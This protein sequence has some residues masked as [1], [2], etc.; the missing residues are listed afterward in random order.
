M[1]MELL[2]FA[3]FASYSIMIYSSVLWFS[4]FLA[5]RKRMW[6]N[7]SVKYT[8][9]VTFLVPAHNEENLIDRCLESIENLDYPKDKIKVIVIDDGST[10]S[11]GSVASRFGVKLIEQKHKGKAA[12]VNNALKHVKTELVACLDA[13]SVLDK[14]YLKKIVTHMKNKNVAAATPSLKVSHKNSLMRDIQYMEYLY[15][16]FLRRLFNF[17]D[18][19]YVIPGP[20]GIYKTEYLKKVGG[21]DEKNLTEDMEVAFR[22]IDN[23]YKIENSIDAYVHTEAPKTLKGLF[24]QRIRWYRGYLQNVFKYSHM[25]SNGKFGN[26]GIFLLPINFVWMIIIG[27]M[28]FALLFTNGAYLLSSFVDWSYIHYSIFTP[29]NLVDV[30][31]VGLYSYFTIVFAI[32]GFLNINLSLKYSGEKWRVKENLKMYF[33]YLFIYPLLIA[34]FWIVSIFQEIFKVERKLLHEN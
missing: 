29:N 3:Y 28:F 4:V 8:P 33:G 27:F 20:G 15:M 7:P 31:S 9:S 32:L 14:T 11:T 30:M 6:E 34:A 22:L 1:N 5:N 26:L 23:G 16:I 12:A 19:Q 24:R 2:D 21:L 10:D 13:D 18:C 25:I 17:F